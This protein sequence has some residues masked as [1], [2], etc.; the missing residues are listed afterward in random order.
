LLGVAQPLGEVTWVLH[1]GIFVV[2]LPAMIVDQGQVKDFKQ[3]DDWKAYF[4][5]CPAWLRWMPAAFGTHAILNFIICLAIV[6]AAPPVPGAPA[7][8]VIFVMFSG[9]WMLFYSAAAATLYSYLVVH[10]VDPAWCCPNYHPVSPGTVYCEICGA[11]VGR[12]E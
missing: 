9:H 8:P 7:P 10:R 5:G 2:W 11:Y 4:P 6:Q 12:P 3:K 1:L